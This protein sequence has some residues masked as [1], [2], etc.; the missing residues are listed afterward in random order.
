M[1]SKYLNPKRN[2]VLEISSIKMLSKKLTELIYT[3]LLQQLTQIYGYEV[4]SNI[5]T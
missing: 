1:L 3:K 4:I 5:I 2:S